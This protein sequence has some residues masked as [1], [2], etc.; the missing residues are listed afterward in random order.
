[1]QITIETERLILRPFKNSDFGDLYEFLSQLKDDEFEGYPN[2]TR[3]NGE[4]QLNLRLDSIEYYA[5]E[6]KSEK[7]V[8]GNIYFGIRDYNARD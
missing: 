4:E 3:E 2:L 1:M 5:I 6:L 7:K 8:I